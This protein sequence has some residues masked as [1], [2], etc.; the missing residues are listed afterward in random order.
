MMENKKE[1]QEEGFNIGLMQTAKRKW[2]GR[3]S[4]TGRSIEKTVELAEKM[5]EE[6]ER[7]V[8]EGE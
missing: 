5:K 8:E 1:T 6:V 2:Y 3:F 7:I 4:V